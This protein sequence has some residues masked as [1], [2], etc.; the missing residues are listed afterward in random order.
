VAR[1]PTKYG[2]TTPSRTYLAAKTVL[3]QAH[4]NWCVLCQHGFGSQM[5]SNGSWAPIFWRRANFFVYN[6]GKCPLFPKNTKKNDASPIFSVLK[7]CQFLAYNSRTPKI[8]ASWFFLES[9]G[10]KWAMPKVY[11]GI[12]TRPQNMG[13]KIWKINEIQLKQWTRINLARSRHI[14]PY[15]PSRISPPKLAQIITKKNVKIVWMY[16]SKLP[17]LWLPKLPEFIAQNSANMR[18][19]GQSN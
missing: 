2:A 5:F 12:L 19:L 9:F 1:L 17:Y 13:A 18:K 15:M 16:L 14:P 6:W 11:G 4:Q 7:Q 3:A 10:N 8:G